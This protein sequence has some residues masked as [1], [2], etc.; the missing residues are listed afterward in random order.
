MICISGSFN[1]QTSF[2][3]EFMEKVI[4]AFLPIEE[5]I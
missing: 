2:Q 1:F 5:K 4:M 3:K